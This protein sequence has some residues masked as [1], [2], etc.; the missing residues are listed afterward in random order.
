VLG[1]ADPA[2][3]T[4]HHTYLLMTAEMGLVGLFLYVLPAVWL[5]GATLTNWKQLKPGGLLGRE[6]LVMLWLLLADHFIVGNFTDL[7]RSN[8]YSTSMWWLVLGWIANI[9][10]NAKVSEPR[11]E[12]P[13]AS[14]MHVR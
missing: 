14:Q 7:I 9:V 3:H 13:I 1:L 5:L 4:S 2:A 11:F 10:Q 6:M 12:Q 8:F